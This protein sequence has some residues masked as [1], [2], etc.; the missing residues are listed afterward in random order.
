[1]RPLAEYREH[2]TFARSI[3]PIVA[4]EHAITRVAVATD[5][6][7]EKQGGD[8]RTMGRKAT[9]P[10]GLYRAHGFF[11]PALAAK[12][13]FNADDLTL[14]W[15]ALVHMFEHDRSAA[16]GL[17]ATRALVLFEHDARWGSAPAHTL[18]DAVTV[19]RR[20]GSTGPARSFKDYTVEVGGGALDSAALPA[21]YLVTASK[22]A[23][24]GYTLARRGS[25]KAD[26][27]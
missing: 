27:A 10:Y 4:L 8:N 13:G 3:E 18:F 9:V 23:P 26:A 11:S 15:E 24:A 19:T 7:A 16:R 20:A 22:D 14:L 21:V 1:M 2:R 6:E 17:M 5:E 25:T 12:T